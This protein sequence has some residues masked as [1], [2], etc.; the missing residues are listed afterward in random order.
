MIAIDKFDKYVYKIGM[1]D[2]G[3]RTIRHD[4]VCYQIGGVAL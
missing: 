1:N 4:D 3:I 2:N